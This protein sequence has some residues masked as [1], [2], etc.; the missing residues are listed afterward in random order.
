MLVHSADAI[1]GQASEYKHFFSNR[2]CR[3]DIKYTTNL[4]TGVSWQ[5]FLDCGTIFYLDCG[6]QNFSLILSDDL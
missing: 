4:V 3:T 5:P 2:P 1:I 6:G